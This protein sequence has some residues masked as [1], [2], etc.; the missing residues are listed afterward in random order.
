MDAGPRDPNEQRLADGIRHGMLR[1]FGLPWVDSSNPAEAYKDCRV[2]CLGIP[3]DIGA[4][5]SPGARYGPYSVRGASGMPAAPETLGRAV[6]GGNIPA[7]LASARGMRD[8]VEKSVAEVLAAGA[9]PFLVGGDHSVSLPVMRAM[10]KA[11][12]PLAVVHFDA[13]PDTSKGMELMSDDPYHHGAPLR[14]ALEEGLIAP[15]QLHQLGIRVSWDEDLT[16]EH[17]VNVYTTDHL[18]D[19]GIR[20][21]MARVREAIGTLPTYVTFDI[22]AVDPAFA[23]GTGTPVPGGLTSREALRLV[24]SLAGLRIVGMDVVE[25][26]PALDQSNITSLLAAALLWRGILASVGLA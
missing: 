3:H 2:V 19:R 6:D 1:F 11:F 8:V 12:G 23:P 21:V 25:V 5:G 16:R 7:P 13:H 14:H 18:A 20:M 15:R 10:H 26:L 4:G 17:G 9:T 24:G 22:D